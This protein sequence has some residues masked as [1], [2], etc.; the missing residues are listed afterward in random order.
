MDFLLQRLRLVAF[1]KGGTLEITPPGG[2][3]KKNAWKK[4]QE[5]SDRVQ[6]G[7]Y[8]GEPFIARRREAT[9]KV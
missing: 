2:A 1:V 7:S 6:S 4:G 8:E 3:M 9:V 5:Q